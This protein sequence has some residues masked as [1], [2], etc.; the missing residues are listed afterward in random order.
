MITGNSGLDQFLTAM[1]GWMSGSGLRY[2][3]T[4][5]NGIQTFVIHHDMGKNTAYYI[6][7]YFRRSLEIMKAKDIE[8][9]S[10]NDTLWV[11]FTV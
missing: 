7:N 8:V 1:E 4:T 3:H 9:K 2:R 5:N 11:E 10:T 6:M